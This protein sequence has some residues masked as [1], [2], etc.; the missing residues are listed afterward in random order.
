MNQFSVDHRPICSAN[1]TIRRPVFA[2]P[3]SLS[4][5]WF[6]RYS[7]C[8]RGGRVKRSLPTGCQFFSSASAWIAS[9]GLLRVGKLITR[10]SLLASRALWSSRVS[11]ME[12]SP[13]KSSRSGGNSLGREILIELILSLWRSAATEP[14]VKH[15]SNHFPN[16]LILFEIES[17]LNVTF[18]QGPRMFF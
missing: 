14:H 1:R 2:S 17:F 11:R 16:S 15:W 6:F 10:D 18:W 4:L 13:V 12:E 3:R 5:H 8:F 7:G 9:V